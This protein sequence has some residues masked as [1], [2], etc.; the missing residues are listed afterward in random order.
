MLG[1]EPAMVE[2]G[3]ELRRQDH[4][5]LRVE[6]VLVPSDESCHQSLLPRRSP[7]CALGRPSTPFCTTLRPFPPLHNHMEP[8]AT[9]TQL[10]RPPSSTSTPSLSWTRAVREARAA[11]R[12]DE[13]RPKRR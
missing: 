2:G 3:P 10:F 7:V 1:Q 13:R 12:S 8:I 4:P 11:K 6:R 9:Q 5:A